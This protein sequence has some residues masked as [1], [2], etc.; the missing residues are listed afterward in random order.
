MEFFIK[1]N[2]TLP[3]LKLQVVKDGRNDFRSFME[4]LQN[5][6]IT[7]S[8]VNTDN[9]IL[10]I[11]SK[12]TYITE[13]FF[14]NPDAPQEFYIYYNFTA[15]DTKTPGRY[16]GEFSIT[17]TEGELIVPIRESLFINI[18]PSFIKT[19]YCC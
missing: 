8:M 17:T 3:T 12:P 2:A 16:M 15:N 7:F 18:T 10:K 6:I 9:G 5:A 4:T 14:D 11:A 1:Q 19:Q 13:K